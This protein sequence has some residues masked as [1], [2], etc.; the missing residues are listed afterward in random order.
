MVTFGLIGVHLGLGGVAVSAAPAPAPS[1]NAEAPKAGKKVCTIKD[2]R[3]TELSGLVATKTGYVVI[4]DGSDEES[5]RK[6][7]FLNSKCAV[8]KPVSFSSPPRDT[9]DIALSPDGTKL[10]IAD[11]GDNVTSPKRRETV[12][13]WIMPAD[14]SKEPVIHRLTY[15]DGPHDAEALLFNGDGTPII[16][17]KSPGKSALYAPTGP[18]Q[19]GTPE[20]VPMKKLG[21][22][23]IP[24]TTTPHDWGPAARMLVTG[25]ATAPDGSRVVLR[26]YTD[27]FEWD[28]TD[29][30]VVAA[31]TKTRP[32]VTAL[33]GE[34]AGEAISYSPDGRNFLTVSETADFEGVDPIIR[35][36]IPAQELAKPA[37]ADDEK[38]D[39][40]SWF[41]DLTLKEITYLIAAVGVLGA[42]LVVVGVVGILRARRRRAVRAN[43]DDER[44]AGGRSGGSP[45]GGG[46]YGGRDNGP[47]GGQYPPAGG[48]GHEQPR[49]NGGTPGRMYGGPQTGS[50][51]VYGGPQSTVGPG[52][53]P[54]GGAVYDGG[55]GYHGPGYHDDPTPGYPGSGYDN[56]GGGRGGHP[57]D[58]YRYR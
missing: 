42:I 53:Q 33:P 29:G 45:G 20:G 7:F 2:E 50:G 40:S 22:I 48:Y 9:E 26:T 56:R 35:S 54:A 25:G 6:V 27:A 28:V 13:L 17:T 38:A 34:P 11:I 18:L 14:G 12:A 57:G 47:R 41:D 39:E 30:D 23:L 37:T 55:A 31:L 58:G 43:A 36:W 8:T 32:R 1:G 24:K 16:V 21:E 5:R 19:P 4:N 15:P 10:Y 3:L 49:A 52:E 46:V 44:A 51:G